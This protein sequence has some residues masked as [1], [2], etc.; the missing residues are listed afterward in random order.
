MTDSADA[1]GAEAPA[2][3]S[4]APIEPAAP[5]APS[6][7]GP[8]VPHKEPEQT[9]QEEGKAEE[10]PKEEESGKKGAK[11]VRDALKKA[12]D[13]AK[14]KQAEKDKAEKA[15]DPATAEAKQ[16]EKQPE[17]PKSEQQAQP[18]TEQGQKPAQEGQQQPKQL[19]PDAPYREAPKGFDE[20]AGSEWA[21]TPLSVRG[22]TH[23]VIEELQN[24]IDEHKQRWEPL[25]QYDE[26]ARQYG[27]NLP[28]ALE[29]YVAFEKLL[30]QDPIRGLQAIADDKGINLR[31]VAAHIMGQKP[32]QVQ[33]EMQGT[34]Q[35]LR[36]QVNTLTQ[37]LGDVTK[38]MSQSFEQN[39]YAK[40]ESFRDSLTEADQKFFDFLDPQIATH[41][42]KGLDLPDAFRKAKEEAVQ[43]GLIAPS[44]AADTGN[45]PAPA[46]TRQPKPANPAGQKSVHG[47][48]SAG[49]EPPKPK[50]GSVP[51]IRESLKSASAQAG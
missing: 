1:G 43:S 33:S 21:D 20:G 26:M 34:I 28:D 39:A 8:Q 19:A 25:K 51:S 17:R 11:S 2:V 23:R 15:D 45:T 5:D 27:T 7:L 36:Q 3:D 12:N 9:P 47:A 32:D 4:G 31:A 14:A 35:Q 6:P 46:E 41:F 24:G 44:N 10:K 42:G 18:A 22:A 50:R 38:N 48:P 37:Q 49:A 29:R 30:N 40:V 13:D 16:A